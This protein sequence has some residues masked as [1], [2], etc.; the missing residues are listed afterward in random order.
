MKGLHMNDIREIIYRLRKGHS[1]RSIGREMGLA[2][3]T[4]RKYRRI[5]HGHGWL[6]MSVPLPDNATLAGAIEPPSPR[7]P[8]ASSVEPY[9]QAVEALRQAGVEM[10]AIH[11]RLR[12]DHGY[13]G[14]YSSVRR[15]VARLE[16]TAPEVFCRIET[17][18][19][20]EAQVDFGSAGLRFED[21]QGRKRR[22]WVFVM[23]LSYSRHQY[24]EFVFDQ[25]IETF[26][27]CHERAFQWFGGVPERIV[28]DNL[29]A[30]VIT[31]DLHDPVLCEP[32]RRLAQHY[33]FVISPNRPATPRHKGKVESGVRYVKRNF[34]AGQRFADLQA[35]NQRGREW[36]MATAG[37]R[38]HGTT[39]QAPLDRF[40]ATERPALAA[41][42]DEPFEWLAAYRAKVHRDCHVVADRR[43][44]SVP[45]RLVG[46]SV[47][48]YVGRRVVE[49][50]HDNLLVTTHPRAG[51]PGERRTRT[52][53]YPAG[54]RAYL[55][56]PPER[57]QED[58]QRVGPACAQLVAALLEQRPTDRLRSVQSLLRLVQ[59]VGAKRLEAACRR[60]LEY[61]DGRYRRV[62]N[63]LDA[64]LEG[65]DEQAP[66]EPL[67]ASASSCRYAR[68][69][70][71]FFGQEA[72]I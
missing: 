39:G 48:V 12:D 62:K 7:A 41:L 37:Q 11:Q 1:Q 8:T 55:E 63:I 50:Y 47:D 59:S 65:A 19:G 23:T 32:Y 22:V 14:S 35:M 3:N 10:V 13:T 53:H 56:H 60:A 42:P 16:P 58:A 34:L 4:I 21:A 33:G 70:G 17:E 71:D 38:R 40:E 43:Y 52:E 30:G 45:A 68:P 24:I 27:G 6:D 29:K 2:R 46:Q 51:E 9:R 67:L 54:K 5:A 28:I 31:A 61:G 57:C 20:H 69:A 36:V 15:F 25:R 26:L 66:R 44:Y 18:P 49:I 72:M 64:G